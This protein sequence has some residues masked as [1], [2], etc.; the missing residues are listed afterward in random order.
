MA[1]HG[2]AR[3]AMRYPASIRVDDEIE[4]RLVTDRDAPRVF[5]LADRNRAYLRPWLPWV[6]RTTSV[7]ETE[8]WVQ[9]SLDQMHRGE[10][11]QTC[12]EYR[13]EL[14]GV[15]GYVY[16]D[17]ANRRVEIGYWL[18]EALQGRGIMTRACRRMVEFAFDSLEVHRVE[19]RADVENRKSRAI[20]ERLGFVQEAV[21]RE[22]VFE[23]GG[24]HDLA[25]Y[26]LLRDEREA[27]RG[28]GSAKP[29]HAE[30]AVP[31]PKE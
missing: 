20:P 11:F 19:I 7:T 21:L 6:D 4:L 23:N 15:I 5:A 1:E 12:V 27:A 3:I 25:M 10:G 9:R 24:Y 22:A 18:S 29:L 28:K 17:V 8:G 31:R 30:P 14:A 13:G 16:L 2:P 26:A